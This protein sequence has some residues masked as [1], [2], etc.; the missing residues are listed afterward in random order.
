MDLVLRQIISVKNTILTSPVLHPKSI[1]EG[2]NLGHDLIAGI[3]GDYH[4][5]TSKNK[6]G[7]L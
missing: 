2:E 5:S 3:K 7:D 6:V 4:K 1:H